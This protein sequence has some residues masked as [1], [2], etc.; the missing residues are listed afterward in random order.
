MNKI[1]IILTILISLFII[2]GC[3]SDPGTIKLDYSAVK[4]DSNSNKIKIEKSIIDNLN[5][6]APDI[7]YLD[8]IDY[9]EKLDK[10]D[11]SNIY[12]GFYL[13]ENVKEDYNTYKEFYNIL[14]PVLD[15]AKQ[16]NIDSVVI[17]I[18]D[19]DK[20]YKMWAITFK[21]NQY[22]KIDKNDFIK[23]I[24]TYGSVNGKLYSKYK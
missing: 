1:K 18:Q 3:S 10:D 2:T 4:N 20:H 9:K 11:F 23:S 19:K 22:N 17:L 12:L 7:V 8:R 14:T 24:N 5:G 16:N 13:K 6:V 21:L 15:Y